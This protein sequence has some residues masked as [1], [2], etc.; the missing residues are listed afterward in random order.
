[1]EKIFY[2][3]KSAYVTESAI[4]KILSDFYGIQNAKVLRTEHGKPYVL[5]APH[6]SVSHTDDFLFI[7]VCEEPIGIDAEKVSRNVHYQATLKR[8]PPNEQLEIN[9]KADFLLHWT[10]KESVVK[11]LGSTLSKELK[12]LTYVKNELFIDGKPF[13]ATLTVFNQQ[14][15]I[16]T[17]C[18]KRDF[19]AAE[20][21]PF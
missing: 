21:I 15:H 18:C 17:V 9:G 14:G 8:F 11:Y 4:Q 7:A 10:V 2:A 12:R 13:P 16:I 3:N 1:M 5:S 6:F 20:F 19:K